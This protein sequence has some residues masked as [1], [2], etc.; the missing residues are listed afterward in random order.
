MGEKHNCGGK[1]NHI[2][3]RENVCLADRLLFSFLI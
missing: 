3:G 1:E 2:K